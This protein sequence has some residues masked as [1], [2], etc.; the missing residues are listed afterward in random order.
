MNEEER[1]FS[2]LKPISFVVMLI[3][4]IPA[5]MTAF[6]DTYL[7]FVDYVSVFG[8]FFVACLINEI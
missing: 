5:M 7:T 3:G 4:F 8:G 6:G 1:I 2:R